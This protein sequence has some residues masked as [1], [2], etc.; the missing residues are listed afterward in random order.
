M[1]VSAMHITAGVY[2][3]DWESGLISDIQVWLEKL[4]PAGLRLPASPDGRRQRRRAPEAHD[5]RAPGHAADHRRRARS[6]AVG[7][8]VL[9]RVR[10]PAPQARRRE[11]DGR[12]VS[13]RRVPVVRAWF[14]AFNRSD[15]ARLAALYAR[16][17]HVRSG[18]R[19]AAGPRGDR[20]TRSPI[21]ARR[22]SRRSTAAR[23][24]GSA[25]WAA[26]RPASRPS[27]SAA[28][29]TAPAARCSTRPGTTTSPS[30]RAG[31]RGSGRSSGRRR[32]WPPRS[33]THR[34]RPRAAIQSGRSSASAP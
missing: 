8:G 20:P 26:S 6:R 12:A 25:R 13:E 23:A 1:L 15:V 33:P 28:K 14:A 16:G 24:A 2:V 17:C 11:G 34:A 19:R 32:P 21:T 22:G 4:A 29:S 18:C 30:S 9:R 5:P 31:S 27:G 3:N 10:R 7:A